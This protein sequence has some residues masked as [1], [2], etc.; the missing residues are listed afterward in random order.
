MK[1]VLDMYTLCCLACVVRNEDCRSMQ[2]TRLIDMIST[3]SSIE[4]HQPV[5]CTR[6]YGYDRCYLKDEVRHRYS[7]ERDWLESSQWCPNHCELSI[8]RLQ[9]HEMCKTGSLFVHKTSQHLHQCVQ[10]E[11]DL[12]LQITVCSCK[13]YRTV[14]V[15]IVVFDTRVNQ[16]N[17]TSE[18]VNTKVMEMT[19]IYVIC[20][21]FR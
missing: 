21:I 13:I 6:W 4:D 11:R 16:D 5:L 1:S 8:E 9:Y 12:L 15:T 3:S 14:D 20:W 7:Y 10:L 19:G 17:G 2:H 18:C